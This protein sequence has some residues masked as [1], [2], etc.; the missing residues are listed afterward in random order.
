MTHPDSGAV[1]AEHLE[2]RR[3]LDGLDAVLREG[4]AAAGWRDQLI[5]GLSALTPRLGAHFARE[6]SS[7]LFDSIREAQPGAAR[8]C[9]ALLRQHASLLR[10]LEA[11]IRDLRD[12]PE[13]AGPSLTGRL[14][15]FMDALEDHESQE[16]SLFSEALEADIGAQD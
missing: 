1:V 12:S 9:D 15:A 10:D 14:R 2:L 6:E 3:T 5:R 11:L 4:P 16:N 7:G 8:A 13:D